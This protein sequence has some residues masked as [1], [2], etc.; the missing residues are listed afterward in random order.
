[1]QVLQLGVEAARCVMLYEES[2]I[3]D[4]QCDRTQVRSNENAHMIDGWVERQG[5]CE[6]VV[7]PVDGVWD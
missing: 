6:G 2:T 7:G 4:R 1:M 5:G 3:G